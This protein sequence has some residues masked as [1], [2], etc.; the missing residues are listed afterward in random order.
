[1]LPI[2][3]L[4]AVHYECYGTVICKSCYEQRLYFKLKILYS[5]VVTRTTSQAIDTVTVKNCCQCK[6]PIAFSQKSVTML[7]QNNY[8]TI[9]LANSATSIHTI[10]PPTSNYA[11]EIVLR[12]AHDTL[13]NEAKTFLY[14]SFRPRGR[15]PVAFGWQ[16]LARQAIRRDFFDFP[17][18][19]V[20]ARAEPVNEVTSTPDIGAFL[21]CNEQLSPTSPP[22]EE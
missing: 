15:P 17:I 10:I 7:S 19:R 2:R 11:S 8:T 12:S 16:F 21:H 5:M 1:M 13:M 4:E 20:R 3:D 18:R 6:D 9:A 14:Y 22:A